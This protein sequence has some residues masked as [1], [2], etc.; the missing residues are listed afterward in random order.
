M[1]QTAQFLINNFCEVNMINHNNRPCVMVSL[2]ALQDSEVLPLLLADKKMKLLSARFVQEGAVSASGTNY[3]TLQLKK[4]DAAV[5][6]GV[7]T[8]AGLAART[9]LA[10][11][12]PAG[13]LLL[14]KDSYLSLDVA[15]TGT[16]SEGTDAILA[17][18]LEVI[19]N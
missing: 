4:D 7:D 17:L 19:G 8:Q 11:Q 3:L 14:E 9:P 16:F 13:G 15:E 5:E 12:L 10:L 1:D 18:D 6:S 2:G